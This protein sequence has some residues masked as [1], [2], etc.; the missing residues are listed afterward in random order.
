MADKR[1]RPPTD[2]PDDDD[3]FGLR[4]PVKR[5]TAKHE[6]AEKRPEKKKAENC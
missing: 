2:D 3:D 1:R 5:P 4:T 6:K